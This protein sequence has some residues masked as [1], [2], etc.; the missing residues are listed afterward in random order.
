MNNIRIEYCFRLPDSSSE[1]FRLEL[2]PYSLELTGNIPQSL[3]DWSKLGFH[4]CPH[5][6]LD[7]INNPYCPLAA[8][9]VN[10]VKRFDGLISYDKIRVDVITQERQISQKTTAQKAISSMMGLVI[11]TCGCPHTAFFKAMGR[12]HLPLASNEE[13]IFRATSMYLLAQY[14]LRMDGRQ[15]DLELKG[16]TKI[17]H[18]MQ[19]VNVAIAKRLRSTSISDSSINAIVILDNYAKSL[20]YAIDKSLNNLRHLFLPFLK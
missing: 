8:N 15:A 9:L 17:Y 12:F 14:F 13:T 20:P 16:L 4:Q 19:I 10:I 1:N 6:P 5:C 11:A 18:N 3:P 7:I 2:N